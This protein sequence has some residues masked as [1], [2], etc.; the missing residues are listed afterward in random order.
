[1]KYGIEYIIEHRIKCK[2]EYII[3]YT[4]KM[5]QDLG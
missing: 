1:M 2:I 4:P 3:E 5:G